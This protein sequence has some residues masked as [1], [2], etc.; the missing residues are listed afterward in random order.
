MILIDE[1]GFS[2]ALDN[3]CGVIKKVKN[4]DGLCIDGVESEGCEYYFQLSIFSL[5]LFTDLV[6]ELSGAIKHCFVL[7]N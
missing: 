4:Q 6:R 5:F 7:H 2:D 3:K 1:E